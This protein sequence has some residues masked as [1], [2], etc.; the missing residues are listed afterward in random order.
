M[1]ATAAKRCSV[2]TLIESELWAKLQN[3]GDDRV[4]VTHICHTL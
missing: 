1:R 2:S 4:A 3:I